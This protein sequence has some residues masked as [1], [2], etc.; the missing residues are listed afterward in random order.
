MN[1]GMQLL[2]RIRRTGVGMALVGVAV[3]VAG[4][5]VALNLQGHHQVLAIILGCGGGLCLIVI[6]IWS[7]SKAVRAIHRVQKAEADRL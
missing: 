5:I 6:G 3:V 7:R 2:Q 1:N 4:A